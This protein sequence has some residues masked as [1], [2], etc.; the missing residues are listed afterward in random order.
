MSVGNDEV[1]A[2]SLAQR[3]D[4]TEAFVSLDVD[5]PAFI[6]SSP[7]LVYWGLDVHHRYQFILLDRDTPVAR[8]AALPIHWNGDPYTLPVRG[9]DGIVEQSL[10][11]THRGATL[12]TLCALEVGVSNEHAGRGLSRVALTALR[13]EATRMGFEHLIVPVRPTG[14][15]DYPDEPIHVYVTRRRDD[16]LF[17]DNWLR[18]HEHLGARMIGLCPTAMTISAPIYRWRQWTDLPF[19]RSGTVAV[20]GAIA[21]VMVNHHLDFAVYVEPNVWMEHTLTNFSR[22][23]SSYPSG[24][25][26]Q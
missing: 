3:P 22:P 5:W 15:A 23:S 12:N 18:V 4:L 17:A 20:P 14:K 21:P 10:T 26:A 1:Q 19:D 13:D 24:G 6:E 11:D 2:F 7:L 25:N 9:W 16:G 8:A